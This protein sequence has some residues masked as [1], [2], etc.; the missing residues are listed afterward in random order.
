MQNADLRTLDVVVVLAYMAGMALLGLVVSKKNTSTE[1]YFVGNRSFPGWA[2]GLSIL[3]TSLSS[4][5]FLSIPADAFGGNWSNLVLNLLLPAVAVFAIFFFIPIFRGRKITTAY[6][7][8]EMRFGPVARLFAAVS[9][10]LFQ[11]YRIGAVLFLV[12]LPVNLATGIELWVVIAVM[13]VLI[14]FYTVLG[15]IEAVIWTDVI[16][17]IVLLA[18]GL[19]ALGFIIFSLPGGL[20]QIVDVGMANNKFDLAVDGW[21][22]SERTIPVLFMLGIYSW[23]Q[24]FATDQTMIQRYA[25]AKSEKAARQATAMYTSI[26]VP[27]WALFYFIGTALFVFYMN[28]GG[29]DVSGVLSTLNNEND[30]VFPYFLLTE[31][32]QGLAGLIIAGLLAAAMSTLDSSINAIST[33][34]TIDVVRP[35]IKKGRSDAYYLKL[36]KNIGIVTAAFMIGSAIFF[37]E[38]PKDSMNDV[39]WLVGSL[40]QGC[41]VGLFMSALLTKRVGNKGVVAGLAI[42]FCVNVYLAFGALGL[43]NTLGIDKYVIGP[44][45]NLVLLVVA[46][47]GSVLLKGWGAAPRAD[48][49]HDGLESPQR[50][51]QFCRRR[52]RP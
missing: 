51:G 18:G 19:F 52:L 20:N 44:L 9:G 45:V 35:Y 24:F 16:Q 17:A 1:A 42:A 37:S 13:G 21:G 34:I 4:M 40:L 6:E 11:L 30:K 47:L 50:K 38:L 36:A 33:V 32:P 39:N 10:I 14:A 43:A 49:W 27:T 5:T 8:I 23:M 28:K 26:V 2:I 41:L 22:L 29:G 25:A 46:Y 7:Y 15:G 3:G 48:R 12:S 31:L